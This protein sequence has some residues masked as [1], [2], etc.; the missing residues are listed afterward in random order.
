MSE[1]HNSTISKNTLYQN[2]IISN[3][4]IAKINNYKFN[5][6]NCNN[7]LHSKYINENYSKA[8]GLRADNFYMYRINTKCKM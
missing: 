6:W 7:I 3:I 4:I 2:V 8:P 1:I 5:K